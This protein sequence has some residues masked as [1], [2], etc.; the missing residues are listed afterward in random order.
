VQ[1]YEHL[2]NE[3][4]NPALEPLVQGLQRRDLERAGLK[5]IASLAC[6]YI[7]DVVAIELGSGVPAKRNHLTCL[8]DAISDKS[9]SGCDI[10]TLNHDV[11][12]ES[13]LESQAIGFVDGFGPRDGDTAP[14]SPSELENDSRTLLLKLHGSINWRRYNGALKKTLT[15]DPNHAVTANGTMAPIPARELPVLLGTFNKIRDYFNQPYF[16]LVAAFRRQMAAIETLVVS[17]YSFRDKG[18]NI[19]LVEWMRGSSNRNM[20]ILDEKGEGCVAGARGAIRNLWGEFGNTRMRVHRKYLSDCGW[21]N[22]VARHFVRG[23]TE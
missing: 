2:V 5:D 9:F 14:W 23:S 20:L 11:L 18:V 6:D 21:Q 4:E 12:I 3:Y 19:I 22:L 7:Q 13:V 8:V 16:D 15:A 10:F 1:L 17:G